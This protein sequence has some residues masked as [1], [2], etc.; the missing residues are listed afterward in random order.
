MTAPHTRNP[1]KHE[2]EVQRGSSQETPMM[3]V[4]NV[5]STAVKKAAA[6][7][8]KGGEFAG[9]KH[10]RLYHTYPSPGPQRRYVGI[11]R[12]DGMLRR[13]RGDGPW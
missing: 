6:M 8:A 11:I 1:E 13:A 7:L 5:E 4:G 2:F 9:E 12:P 3:F 10:V